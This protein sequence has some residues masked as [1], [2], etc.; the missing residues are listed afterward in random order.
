MHVRIRAN[1]ANGNTLHLPTRRRRVA[2][3]LAMACVLTAALGLAAPA[4]AQ[5]SAPLADSGDGVMQTSYT[6]GATSGAGASYSRALDTVLRARYNTKSYGQEDGNLDLGTFKTFIWNDETVFFADG[7]VTLSDEQGVGYNVGGGV[8]YLSETAFTPDPLRITSASVWADGTSTE[9]DNFFPQVGLSWES[10]GDLVDF[11]FNGYAPVGNR[12]QRGRTLQSGSDPVFLGNSLAIPTVTPQDM[13]FYNAELEAAVRLGDREAWGFGGGYLLFD[14]DDSTFGGRA[15]VRGYAVPDVM[16]QL[17][18]SQDDVFKTNATFALTWFVG[19]TRT[20]YCATGSVIDRFREPV[21]RNDYVAI[22]TTQVSGGEVATDGDDNDLQ[23]VHVNSSAAAGGD[24]TIEN[25]LND[26]GDVNGN[27]GTGDIVFVHADSVFNSQSVVLQDDQRMLGEGEGIEH[28]VTTTIGGETATVV[29]PESSTGAADGTKPTIASAMG[30]AVTLADSNEVANFLIDGNGVTTIGIDGSAA[31]GVTDPNLHDLMIQETTGDGI[32]LVA[33]ARVDTEDADSDDDTTELRIPFAVMIDEV[34]FDQVGGNDIN[35]DAQADS[36]GPVDPD[37]AN[38]DLVGNIALSNITST[39]VGG[40]SLMVANLNSADGA[41]TMTVDDYDYD[42]G[43]GASRGFVFD[44]TMS[45]VTITNST[46]TGGTMAGISFLGVTEGTIGI[47]STNTV[48]DVAGTTFLIDGGVANEFIATLNVGANIDNTAGQSLDIAGVGTGADLNFTGDIDDM[49][50]GMAIHDNDGGD[51]TFAIGADLTFDTGTSTAIALTNN[52]GA[53]IEFNDTLDITTD[54]ATGFLA[55]GGGTLT[56]LNSGMDN[57]ITT[58]NATAVDIQGMTVSNNEVEFTEVTRNVG[59]GTAINLLNNTGDTIRIGAAS[60]S[61]NG[62]GG[63]IAAAGA[64]D[65]VVITDSEDVQLNNVEINYGGGATGTGVAVSNTNNDPMNVTLSNVDVNDA[66]TGVSVD[67]TGGGNTFN[68]A[69]SNGT[70]DTTGVAV[71]A[72]NVDNLQLTGIT[73]TGAG[74]TAAI[75]LNNTDTS[76]MAV[77]M[78]NVM[79]TTAG[80]DGI[81]ALSNNTGNFTLNISNS[82]INGV[83]ND[84]LDLTTSGNS[85]VEVSLISNTFNNN[86]TTNIDNS[87]T[88]DL[89]V[90]NTQVTTGNEVAFLLDLNGNV[91]TANVRIE[92]TASNTSSFT[93]GNATA[94]DFTATDVGTV[95]F[96]FEDTSATNS[97]A[98]TAATIT[99]NG[100]TLMNATITN[101][102]FTNPGAGEALDVESAGTA[103]LNLNLQDNTAATASNDLNLIE[104]SGTFRVQDLA[105][106]D[107]NN[108]GDVTFTPNMAAFDNFGGTVPTPP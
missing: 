25:P 33:G 86:V 43:A 75:D 32:A 20:D 77:N 44:T 55:T 26:L 17:A 46:V 99:A 92:E 39:N 35:I 63:T 96:L 107:A 78:N 14:G 104:T 88:F 80:G 101:N 81:N 82:T 40:A 108:P 76:E 69:L 72:T 102:L 59:G 105:N 21:L 67:G 4:R 10:L 12:T 54:G 70:L 31:A 95:N 106:V 50:D 15:G 16:V 7:Q 62:A 84:A 41:G 28:M 51:I 23:F 36:G 38:V 100:N 65:A 56:V 73:V 52:T 42:G 5:D 91:T 24:G 64:D 8:R 27:S 13:A 49:G 94:F 18:V 71:D 79:I 2:N 98:S 85:D 61:T 22:R 87:G 47:D 66:Q 1:T 34:M 30:S 3:A 53:N 48:N 103:I 6:G 89:L 19:R 97:S 58:A 93:A 11:R 45:D 9:A 83:A 68:V 37:D 29:L 90:R 57:S 74:G 60:T